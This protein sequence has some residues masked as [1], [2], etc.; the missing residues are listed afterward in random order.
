MIYIGYSDDEK[1]Q[2]VADYMGAH[3]IARLVVISPEKFPLLIDGADNVAY[4]QTIMYVTFY[5][6]LQEI[7]GR[8]LIVLSEV[9]R[10][11]NRN[12][13]TYNCIRH[14]LNQTTHQLVFQQLPQ[15]DERDDFMILFDF[16]TRSRWKRQRFDADL[17]AD[18]AQ[19]YVRPMP[20]GFTA[21][22]V[23]TAPA[24]KKKYATERS[25]RFETI[26]LKDPHTI[27]RNLYLIGGKDKV[28]YIDAMTQPQMSL[29]DSNGTNCRYV[30]R[31]KRLGHDLV[32]TYADVT[33]GGAPYT[34]V[35]FPHRFI[36]FS[37]FIKL[38]DQA[39]SRV[40][41]A[42]LKVDDWYLRRYDE[43]AARIHETYA[44]LQQ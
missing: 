17:I 24:T 20:V 44:S 19:V 25:R 36:D 22:P 5:R 4:E 1:R 31:N 40:L 8:T 16:V 10:T 32:V 39:A 35:E 12:D 37:D 28:A 7:D 27:P 29:F 2:I 23:P 41:V 43:W 14:Y 42:D 3:D 21:V 33:A 11:Q 13:L 34:V 6:L 9:L 15:I 30:A 26:G 38:T 18:N